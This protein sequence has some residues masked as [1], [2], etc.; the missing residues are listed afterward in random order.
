MIRSLTLIAVTLITI[1]FTEKAV[2]QLDLLPKGVGLLQYGYRTYSPVSQQYDANGIS[3]PIGARFDQN[4]DSETMASGAAGADLQR[5]V[6]E[7]NSFSA[8]QGSEDGLGSSLQ[9]GTLQGDVQADIQA[10]VFGIGFGLTRWLTFFAGVPLI[11]AEVNTELTFVGNNNAN[12]IRSQLGD[13]A[14]DELSAGL[15]QAAAIN[16]RQVQGSIQQKGYGPIERWSHS[17]IGDVRVGLKTGKK[18]R[19]ARRA[20]FGLGLTS[21]LEI[22]TGYTDD[23]DLL[24]DVSLG[25]GYYS[26]SFTLEPRL[27][28]FRYIMIG[29][30]LG[31]AKNFATTIEKRLPE[32]NE[33]LVD[34]SRKTTVNWQPGDDTTVAGSAG[35]VFSFAS[36]TYKNGMT[37][38]G[39]DSYTGSLVGNY[40][41]LAKGTESL[42]Q[43]HEGIVS[44]SSADAYRRGKVPI[45]F[46]LSFIAHSPYAGKNTTIQPYY[47]ISLTSFFSSPWTEAPKKRKKRAKFAKQRPNK[48]SFTY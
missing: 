45:P 9:L 26:A 10:Q 34:Q 43:Y 1:G 11:S 13:L 41:A 38:H 40:E 7:L 6:T 35:L 17:G 47:E 31:Y 12:A 20:Q 48:R 32:G 46:I 25:K 23:P 28:F 33:S 22:P 3:T 18:W 30:D 27:R 44:L 36:L 2:A 29:A 5:L 24:T 39:Q 37:Q 8:A 16:A 42:E 19:M 4:F 15:Q 14:F 21:Q